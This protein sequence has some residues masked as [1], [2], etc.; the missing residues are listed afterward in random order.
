MSSP[1]SLHMRSRTRTICSTSMS[2]RRLSPVW[3]RTQQQKSCFKMN[4]TSTDNV[5]REGSSYF[6]DEVL[7]LAQWVSGDEGHFHGRCVWIKHLK[8]LRDMHSFLEIFMHL[9][10]ITSSDGYNQKLLKVMHHGTNAQTQNH[11]TTIDSFQ[12][13]DRLEDLEGKTSIEPQHKPVSNPQIFRSPLKRIKQ[14]YVTLEHK[15]SHKGPFL[16]V[17]IYASS[18]RWIN[19]ISIDVWFGQYFNIS[20][21]RVQKHQNIEN[22]SF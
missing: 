14:R 9:L 3:A 19:N 8:R 13:R 20:N 21:L 17:E 11:P 6:A 10:Y 12:S 22:S 18:K 2:C 7:V 1:S 15:T 16:E 4:S 5:T